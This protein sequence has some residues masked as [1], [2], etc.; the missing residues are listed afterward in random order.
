MFI[1]F[2]VL[3][4]SNQS[5]TTR[6]LNDQNAENVEGKVRIMNNLVQALASILVGNQLGQLD[7]QGKYNI[8]CVE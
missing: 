8:F 4:N 5:S 7:L 1:C 2:I 6:G 3:E